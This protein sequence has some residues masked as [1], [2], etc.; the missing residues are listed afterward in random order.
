MTGDGPDEYGRR[1]SAFR[2][3]RGESLYVQVGLARMM[4]LD[5]GYREIRRIPLN[6]RGINTAE[7]LTGGSLIFSST[8]R[9]AP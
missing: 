8:E 4:V 5:A 3:A 9:R 6:I 7:S 2:P 1:I